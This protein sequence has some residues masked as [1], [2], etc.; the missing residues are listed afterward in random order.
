VPPA[1]SPVARS[2]C[3]PIAATSSGGGCAPGTLVGSTEEA[4]IS[5]PAKSALPGVNSSQQ[6][7]EVLRSRATGRR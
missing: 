5:S 2:A 3:G 4:V 6:H 7:R 1:S